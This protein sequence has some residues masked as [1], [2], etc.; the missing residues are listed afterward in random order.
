MP[1][2]TA[3][4]YAPLPNSNIEQWCIVV[5]VTGYALFVTSQYEAVLTYA[6][7]RFGKVG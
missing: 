4:L 3:Y 1:G 2:A 7:Q 5:T 6:N